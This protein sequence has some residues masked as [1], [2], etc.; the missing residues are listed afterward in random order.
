VKAAKIACNECGNEFTQRRGDQLYCCG[1][2]K[3]RSARRVTHE[4]LNLLRDFIDKL[5]EPLPV[6]YSA[7]VM[8]CHIK[9]AYLN[10]EEARLVHCITGIH[11][12]RAASFINYRDGHSG[13]SASLAK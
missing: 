13:A 12:D 11:I 4:K 8:L 3:S 10:D 9:S 7:L 1:A 2:C 5:P 6:A